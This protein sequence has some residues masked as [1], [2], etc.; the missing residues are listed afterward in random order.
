MTGLTGAIV[1]VAAGF[2]AGELSVVA[3]VF[4][5]HWAATGHDDTSGTE[6]EA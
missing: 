3:A 1:G 4:G 6:A 5:F 2:V